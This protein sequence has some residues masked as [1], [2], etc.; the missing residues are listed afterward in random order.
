MV[1]IGNFILFYSLL[2]KYIFVL[3]VNVH[4]STPHLSIYK[5]EKNNLK[6][7]L[8]FLGSKMKSNL[9]TKYIILTMYGVDPPHG[10]QMLANFDFYP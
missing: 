1:H 10:C 3:F 7:L 8:L 9:C 5:S 6:L 4:F 2:P